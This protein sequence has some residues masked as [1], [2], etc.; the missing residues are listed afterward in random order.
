MSAAGLCRGG[1]DHANRQQRRQ[2]ERQLVGRNELDDGSGSDPTGHIVAIPLVTVT[3]C[4]RLLPNNGL[5]VRLI[6][7]PSF[8]GHYSLVKGFV[9]KEAPAELT[10]RAS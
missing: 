8:A 9:S 1:H 3:C 2:P 5:Q 4:R 7:V 6:G 10:A